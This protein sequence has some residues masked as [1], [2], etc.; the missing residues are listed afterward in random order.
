MD[1]AFQIWR[2]HNRKINKFKLIYYM[3]SSKMGTDINYAFS[4]IQRR[5]F[6]KLKLS[7]A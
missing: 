3:L 7:I 5:K 4:C 1:K 2:K 6:Q